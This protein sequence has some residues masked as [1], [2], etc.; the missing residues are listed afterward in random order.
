MVCRICGT[1]AN[2]PDN[3]DVCY[4]CGTALKVLNSPA[5]TRNSP[6]E[7]GFYWFWG[8]IFGLA[9]S[10]KKAR[11]EV[12][13]AHRVDNGVQPPFMVLSAHNAFINP[14]EAIGLWQRIPDPELP[15]DQLV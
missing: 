12:V 15:T 7:D 5:W 9:F 6:T 11:L 8:Y 4:G 10:D 2:M 13:E 14:K 1:A 3:S